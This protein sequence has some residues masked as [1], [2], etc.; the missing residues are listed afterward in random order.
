MHIRVFS[1]RTI[2]LTHTRVL[3]DLKGTR[4]TTM[5]DRRTV[6]PTAIHMLTT[7]VM[8]TIPIPRLLASPLDDVLVPACPTP[9]QTHV[10]QTHGGSNAY[11]MP[12]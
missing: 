12:L 6:T 1:H 5:E 10:A 7:M 2:T 3:P 8:I 11:M 4:T 9:L